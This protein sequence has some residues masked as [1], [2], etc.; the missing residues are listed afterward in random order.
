MVL[1]Q[2]VE[3]VVVYEV[4]QLVLLSQVEVAVAARAPE[5]PV[6]QEVTEVVIKALAAAEEVIMVM[7][8]AD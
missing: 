6:R 3:L 1:E 5:L 8:W 4:M 7:V 2:V